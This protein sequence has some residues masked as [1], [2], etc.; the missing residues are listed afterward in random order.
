[1][2]PRRRFLA[3]TAA[4]S[5]VPLLRAAEGRRPLRTVL[6]GSGWWGRNILREALA[7]G[8]CTCVGLCD[9]DPAQLAHAA[10]EV[11]S[12][13]N[14][15]PKSYRDFR[16]CLAAEKPDIAIIATPDHWHALQTIAA[17]KAGAHVFVEKPTAHTVNES[18]AMVRVAKETGR[19]VQVGLHRRI[20]PHHVNA[21]R[22]LREGKV[23][24][25]GLVQ[26]FVH[27]GG[28]TEQPRPNSEP[29]EG[30]DWDLYCGPAPLRPFNSRIHPGGWRLFMDFANGIIGDWGVHWLDQV[31][32]WTEEKG[33]RR[34]FS[35]GSRPLSGAPLVSD[36]KQTTD[37]PE[38]QVAIFEFEGFT[39]TWENRRYGENEAARHPLGVCFHGTEGTLHIGWRDGWTFHPAKKGA[40]VVHEDHQLQE[41]D[42][43]NLKLL[44]EDFLKAIDTGSSPAANL[45]AAHR[46]SILPMLANAS[47]KLGRSLAWDPAR[48]TIPDDPAAALL[49]RPYRGP[50][51]YP[52]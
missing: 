44:W 43:H 24:K 26:C 2:T 15:D 18:R 16:E 33:P 32:L 35:S 51:K 40:A 28:S 7:S 49:S 8:R 39:A 34:V 20:G 17:L 37:A 47:M 29:P 14:A 1:M 23:G 30:M 11:R 12:L 45:E 22:F 52:A 46:S 38:Q 9:V 21:M 48:E 3:A 5:A 4:F 27:S 13:T 41:P 19:V 10:D 25:I 36:A 42:G 6:I 50:W 31:M